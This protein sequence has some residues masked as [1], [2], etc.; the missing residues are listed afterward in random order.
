M[1][2]NVD[3]SVGLIREQDGSAVTFWYATIL[4]D[5]WGVYRN[6]ISIIVLPWVVKYIIQD[7]LHNP[8]GV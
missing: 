1:I 6:R 3:I 5:T 7:V 2:I 8:W 4:W